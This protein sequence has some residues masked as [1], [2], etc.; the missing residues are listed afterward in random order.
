MNSLEFIWIALLMVTIFILMFGIWLP[1][2]RKNNEG[3]GAAQ[4]AASTGGCTAQSAAST[5]G[6]TAQSAASTGGRTAQSAVERL[7]M[8]R[9]YIE[10]REKK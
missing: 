10:N 5:G 7:R 9:E 1:I 2:F 6:R 4:S 3:F 8:A